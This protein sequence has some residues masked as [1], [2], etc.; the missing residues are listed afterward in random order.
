MCHLRAPPCG[1]CL[2]CDDCGGLALRV[3]H[4]GRPRTGSARAGTQHPRRFGVVPQLSLLASSPR[5]FS[6]RHLVSNP[7]ISIRNHKSQCLFDSDSFI[8]ASPVSSIM[9]AI[10][11][12]VAVFAG[13]ACKCVGRQRVVPHGCLRATLITRSHALHWRAT[14]DFATY[15]AA[16]GTLSTQPP[17][18]TCVQMRPRRGTR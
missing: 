4:C 18:R 16:G 7:E 1:A 3:A 15:D 2:V 9:V 6:S 11:V 12:D 10:M 14:I 13:R 5:L 8:G 17:P